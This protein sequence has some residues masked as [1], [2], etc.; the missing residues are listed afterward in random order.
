MNNAADVF[1]QNGI[2][3]TEHAIRRTVERTARG[4]TPESVVDTVKT[5]EKYLDTRHNN[6]PYFKDGVRVSVDGKGTVETVVSQK[7]MNNKRFKRV[8]EN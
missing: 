1:E 3:A 5:G 8:E 6:Y 4:I 2:N 7:N